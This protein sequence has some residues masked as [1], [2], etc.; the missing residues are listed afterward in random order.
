MMNSHTQLL[1]KHLDIDELY[2]KLKEEG[3]KGTKDTMMGHFLR[4]TDITSAY[5]NPTS[6]T[7]EEGYYKILIKAMNL[8]I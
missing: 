5:S 8:V 2:R 4:A 6:D 1:T 3:Y 7:S